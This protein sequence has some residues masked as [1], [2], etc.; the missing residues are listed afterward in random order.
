MKLCGKM[1]AHGQS[2]LKVDRRL[3]ATYLLTIYFV[4]FFLNN[5]CLMP[6]AGK[7]GNNSC[8]LNMTKSVSSYQARSLSDLKTPFV[9]PN[10]LFSLL[11]ERVGRLKPKTS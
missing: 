1:L 5:P 7:E 3:V 8:T 11:K 2:S 9:G 6:H 10:S 4:N